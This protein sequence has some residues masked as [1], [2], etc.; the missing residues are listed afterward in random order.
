MISGCDGSC[1]GPFTP[2]PGRWPARRATP[3]PA[4]LIP[5]RLNG[6]ACTARRAEKR[7]RPTGFEP[8]TFGFVDR[9]SG[10]NVLQINEA[11]A[12]RESQG[13]G[14]PR[15]PSA[16]RSPT[17]SAKDWSGGHGPARARRAG[18]GCRTFRRIRSSTSARPLRTAAR[19]RRSDAHL[20]HCDSSQGRC[21]GCSSQNG[22]VR[23][24]QRG[25][26]G[27]APHCCF[28]RKRGIGGWAKQ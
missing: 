22:P 12:S 10:A 20:A 11:H 3:G 5:P 13:E 17:R 16:T 4:L 26:G 9:T 28:T 18:C 2:E 24:L 14:K 15:H 25:S 1:D 23:L 6:G 21:R 7:T 27:D 8:V 19:R